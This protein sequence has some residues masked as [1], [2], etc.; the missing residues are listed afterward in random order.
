MNRYLLTALLFFALTAQAYSRPTDSI[1]QVQV[2]KLTN[3]L[4]TY[5]AILHTGQW[6]DIT[7]REDSLKLWKQDAKTVFALK[8]NLASTGDLPTLTSF[9]DSDSILTEAL[10]NF[11]ERH[12]LPASGTLDKATYRAINIPVSYRVKL[13]EININRW[14]NFA[15]EGEPLLVLVNIPDYSL[16]VIKNGTTELTSKVI[17]GKKTT[18]TI[19]F[20]SKIDQVTLNPSWYVPSSIEKNELLAKI[21]KDPSY[22]ARNNMRLYDRKDRTKEIDPLQVDWPSITAANFTYSIEQKP[23]PWNALG[24]IKF[25]MP[26]PYSIYLHDTPD[27]TLF[28]TNVR[29]YSHGCVRVERPLELAVYL[30]QTQKGWSREAIQ[31]A[32]QTGNTRVIRLNEPVPVAL[33]YFTSWVNEQNE[34]QFRNDIYELDQFEL[35]KQDRTLLGKLLSSA[36]TLIK[37]LF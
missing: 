27:K 30:L 7:L 34:L 23:G 32:I 25:T 6:Q 33:A 15:L 37:K 10:K 19:R 13:I 35:K 5:K 29:A 12:G 2:H 4:L 20:T 31:K 16:R 9:T 22:L 14:K 24:R 26:N 8:T 11:Q 1:A 21:K 3:A 36:S 28:N 18:E 17:V